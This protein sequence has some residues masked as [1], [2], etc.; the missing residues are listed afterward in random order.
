[1]GLALAFLWVYI[2]KQAGDGTL[3]FDFEGTLYEPAQRIADGES[4]YPRPVLSEVKVGNPAL[5]PPLFML[6]VV[7]LSVLPWAL[8]FAFWVAILAAGMVLAVRVLGIRDTRCYVAVLL[9]PTVWLGLTF[10]NLAVLLVPLAAVAWAYRNRSPVLSGVAVGVAIA[11]KLYLWPLAI[12]LLATRRYKAFGGS[13]GAAFAG[14]IGAW[15]LIGF[16][17]LREYPDLLRLG[18]QVY[19]GHS[20]SL[21]TAA[22]AL[23]L[24]TNAGRALVLGA[25]VVCSLLAVLAG[26]RGEDAVSY[27]IAVLGAIL[28]ASIA[29]PFTFAL[30]A[31]PIAIAFPYFNAVWL[32]PTL[33]IL[34]EGLPRPLIDAADAPPG[35]PEGV[36]PVIWA[37]N[38]AEPAFWPIVGYAAIASGITCLVVMRLRQRATA[39]SAAAVEEGPLLCSAGL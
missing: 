8:A 15:A 10:G 39:S 29:W 13:V 31:V 28:G 4:P 23:D 25:A 2:V 18:E 7:P 5:Y 36:P 6:A 1:V 38:N 24:S 11:A 14:T 33:V 20:Y 12:W 27:S 30:L 35:R 3:G 21:A 37:I 16:D 26:R 22:A 9:P 34:A 19:S 17:G 32:A